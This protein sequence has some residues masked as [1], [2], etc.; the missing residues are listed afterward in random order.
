MTLTIPDPGDLGLSYGEWRASQRQALELLAEHES[1]LLALQAPTGSGKSGIGLGWALTMARETYDAADPAVVRR[2]LIL[3]QRNVELTQYEGLLPQGE[4]ADWG[5]S[6]RGKSRYHC[7]LLMAELTA[8]ASWPE[9]PEG[10]CRSEHDYCDLPDCSWP[11]FEEDAPCV[12]MKKPED[13]PFYSQCPYYQARE[14]ARKAP[15]LATNYAYGAEALANSRIAGKFDCLVADEAHDLLDILTGLAA[16]SLNLRLLNDSLLDCR[17]GHYE[18]LWEAAQLRGDFSGE[19]LAGELGRKQA[20]LRRRIDDCRGE[21]QRV[22]GVAQ[23]CWQ[24]PEYR[25]RF[26][27]TAT[28]FAARYVGLL[29]DLLEVFPKEANEEFD[30]L[31]LPGKK[32]R[33]LRGHLAAR[34]RELKAL[35]DLDPEHYSNYVLGGEA[36]P[37]CWQFLPVDLRVG[38]LG[39]EALWNRVE[40]SV[41]MSGTLPPRKALEYCLGLAE[42]PAV[43][44]L[45]AEFPPEQ[46]PVRVWSRNLDLRYNTGYKDRPLL[47][48]AVSE[49]LASP[50]LREHKGMVL[51]P[52]YRWMNDYLNWAEPGQRVFCHR[53][54]RQLPARLRAFREHSGPAV[55]MSPTA[56]QAIDLPDDDCRYIIVPRPFWPVIAE[57]SVDWHRRERLP[58][59]MENAAGLKMVQ[60]AG[61]GFRSA[62]DWCEVFI[63]DR[64]WGQGLMAILMNSL[65]D[66]NIQPVSDLIPGREP[67]PA[68][69]GFD[70]GA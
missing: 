38:N 24:R 62:G 61:R 36:E 8:A 30:R 60:A 43:A 33:G 37:T 32:M 14:K 59:Y 34:L 10:E 6:L 58:D 52:S 51:W 19:A 20:G 23:D 11:R 35:A 50:R 48:G 53:D 26:L 27:P 65:Y 46:R 15:V 47:F 29:Q 63:L 54:A 45:D 5:A 64:G 68:L 67:E 22:V 25:P 12:G 13:C 21:G 66:L 7:P 69:A 4:Y 70:D 18:A 31:N 9:R 16:L 28:G 39:A 2:T 55:F 1:G 41:A 44:V 17:E 57:G 56:Y 42:R 40:R 49:L 3:T